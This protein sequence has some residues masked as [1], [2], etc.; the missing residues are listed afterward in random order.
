MPTPTYA[1]YQLAQNNLLPCA[2]PILTKQAVLIID[3]HIAMFGQLMCLYPSQ[4]PAMLEM[5]EVPEQPAIC[6]SLHHY[7]DLYH[8]EP[9][10]NIFKSQLTTVNSCQDGVGIP[11]TLLFQP[12]FHASWTNSRR[13][14]SR[15]GSVSKSWQQETTCAHTIR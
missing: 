11:A 10:L 3:I 15:D 9:A 1:T 7:H 5:R 4:I 6:F 14:F 13:F 2:K 8:Y 12:C